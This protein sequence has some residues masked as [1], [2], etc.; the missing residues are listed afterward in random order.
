LSDNCEEIKSLLFDFSVG[1]VDEDQRARVAA[2][3][4]ECR[5]CAKRLSELEGTGI[6]LRKVP[7][8]TDIEANEEFQNATR[9]LARVESQKRIAVMREEG[10]EKRRSATEARA[11]AA[12]AARPK[13]GVMMLAA[14]AA[15]AAV[16]VLLVVL[17]RM[18]SEQE[19]VEGPIGDSVAKLDA[20]TGKIEVFFRKRGASWSDLSAGRGLFAGES[21]RTGEGAVARF[22]LEGGK[23]LWL[24]PLT[25]G[26]FTESLGGFGVGF[27]LERGAAVLASREGPC[28]IEAGFGEVSNDAGAVMLAS[29]GDAWWLDVFRAEALVK[30][31]DEV[32][33][34]EGHC[35]SIGDDGTTDLGESNL[36]RSAVWRF[37]LLDKMLLAKLFTEQKPR[38]TDGAAFVEYPGL[39]GRIEAG[40]PVS[41]YGVFAGDVSLA[42]EVDGWQ[43]GRLSVGLAAPGRKKKCLKFEFIPGSGGANL[44][45]YASGDAMVEGRGDPVPAS[46]SGKVKLRLER[47]GTS[48]NAYIGSKLVG[49]FKTDFDSALAPVLKATD[50][51]LTILSVTVSGMP[52]PEWVGEKL[53]VVMPGE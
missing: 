52:D 20:S 23:E 50:A 11:A 10:V 4:L 51:S 19:K 32:T 28:R 40:K 17:Q 5:D 35:A 43:P 37:R 25:R 36:A 12:A 48:A 44:V 8:F 13:T 26:A 14:A 9:R 41:P 38:L 3:L 30:S 2:H 31:T 47:S 33:I 24:G 18:R 46:L 45:R 21:V 1:E 42:V 34:A 49:S 53:G 6:A 22:S 7:A 39:R 29:V 15:I 16:I 27:R